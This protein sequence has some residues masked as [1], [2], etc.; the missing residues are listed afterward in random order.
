MSEFM[1]LLRGGDE[2]YQNFTE[3]EIEAMLGRYRQ[4]ASD[5]AQNGQLLDAFKLKDG[6]QMLKKRG[7]TVAVDGPFTETKETIGGYYMIHAADFAEA[8]ALAQA[9]PIFDVGGFVEIRKIES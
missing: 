6:G 7:T 1:L 4:W 3:A 8:E 9:C 2:G 5:L